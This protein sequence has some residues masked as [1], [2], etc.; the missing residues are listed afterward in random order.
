L[1]RVAGITDRELADLSRYRE[2]SVFGPVE[3]LVLDLAVGMA[4]TPVNVSEELF[5]ELRRHFTEAQL[6][7]LVTDIAM[8]NMRSR[9]NRAFQCQ[10]AGFSEG[11]F[12]PLP[13]K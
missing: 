13:E 5:A 9:F 12:C 8:G 2:S 4:M 7:E 3:K 11:T 1:G 6:V 10:P